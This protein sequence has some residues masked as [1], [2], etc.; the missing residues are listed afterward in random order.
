MHHHLLHLAQIDHSLIKAIFHCL[1]SDVKNIVAVIP[2]EKKF[3]EIKLKIKANFIK[4]NYSEV[5][6]IF[7][8]HWS[9][10]ECVEFFIKQ[11]FLQYEQ[12]LYVI[13]EKIHNYFKTVP[14]NHQ[15]IADF[16]V[17]DPA[18]FDELS[19]LL[20]PE[21]KKNDP[22][23]MLAAKAFILFLFQHGEFGARI[24]NDPPSFFSKLEKSP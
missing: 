19:Y 2:F 15:G 6:N 4:R 21:G 3:R 9:E 16:P 20:I 10:I 22:R 23:Y 13:V 1:N 18:Y 17:N 11:N 5:Q 8:S 24:P 14:L 12:Q 7:H